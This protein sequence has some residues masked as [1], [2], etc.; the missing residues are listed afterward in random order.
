MK[1]KFT[2]A[3]EYGIDALTLRFHG[4]KDFF[5][6][7]HY[8]RESLVHIRIAIL[9]SIFIYAAFLLLDYKLAPEL[10]GPYSLVRFG[11]AIPFAGIIY[12]YSYLPGFSRNYQFLVAMI[13]IVAGMGIIA[14]M[15][16]GWKIGN[17]EIVHHYY[18]GI[19]LVFI[20]SYNF[21][22]LRFI[23]ASISGVVLVIVYLLLLLLFIK[24]GIR[25][26]LTSG[27]FLIA[28]NIM[29]MFSA[30]L[31]EY[32]FRKEFYFNELLKKEKQKTQEL[33]ENLE[34]EIR[35][36]TR[37]LNSALDHAEQSDHLKSMFLANMSHEIRTPLN[38]ILGFTDLLQNEELD[39][40]RRKMY[41][42]IIQDRSNYLLSILNN[43]IDFSLI[44]SN[45]LKFTE[46][47]FNLN[48]SLNTLYI[49]LENIFTKGNLEF[50]LELEK[51]EE[52][53]LIRTDKTKI[54]QILTNLVENA[55]KYTQKGHVIMGYKFFRDYLRI[56]VA[57]TGPGIPFEYRKYIFRSF[58]KM[59]DSDVE[60]KSGAGLGLAICKGLADFIGA[61]IHFNT[62]ESKGTRFFLDL[63]TSVIL[64]GGL[65]D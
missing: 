50:K 31:F 21:L 8:Y 32:A 35:N 24:P 2:R 11:I 65:S 60:F 56:Y 41:L 62:E 49:F 63:P 64:K 54:E 25:F 6:R 51:P 58:A 43:I 53:I 1:N 13:T 19:I 55:A 33:N 39:E 4:E 26:T 45:Q 36:R 44:K 34:K 14:M 3:N 37:E 27:F 23:W 28:A 59:E 29:G 42:N 22:K 61:N 18:V 12:V 9:V 48:H 57:D 5:F 52:E 40:K 20:F 16:L 7:E 30:Y 47:E 15:Y 10:I 46:T 17:A 38:G